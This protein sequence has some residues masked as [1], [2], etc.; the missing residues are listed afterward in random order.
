MAFWHRY[1]SQFCG[2]RVAIMISVLLP[3]AQSCRAKDDPLSKEFQVQL[4]A[5]LD[6]QIEAA[7]SAIASHPDSVDLYS[8]RGDAYFFAGKFPEAVRD[9]DKMVA[10]EPEQ[11]ASH[12]RRGIAYF[13][14]GAFDKAAGQ[15]TRY[16][17]FDNVDR[18]NGIWRYL[19]QYKA[20]GKDE[21]RKELLKYDKDDREP[22]GD[23]YKMFA[24]EI[25]GD[26]VLQR[27]EAKT[28]SSQ[29]R[30]KQRFYAELYVGL[31]DLVEDRLESAQVHL[32]AATMNPWGPQ[33]GYGPAWM[34]HVGR[35]Q[36]ELLT[37]E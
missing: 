34:W 7:T 16:H 10:L 26:E 35:L 22:F 37:K 33:A 4:A 2:L 11:D 6:Q 27:I 8:R 1:L 14:I 28:L 24:G 9:Y 5:Q 12:W 19:S 23:I 32:R 21:A 25:T 13:Y 20:K 29:E 30:E 15:F 17:A 18:E 3:G 31:N 36:H